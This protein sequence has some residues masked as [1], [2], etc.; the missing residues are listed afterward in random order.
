MDEW[1][2]VPRVAVATALKAQEQGVAQLRKSPDE[3][4]RSAIEKIKEVRKALD[5][6]TSAGVILPPPRPQL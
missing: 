4:H 1:E 3:L 6:L 5:V 2:V